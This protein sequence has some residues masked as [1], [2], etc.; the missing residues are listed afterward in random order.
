MDQ[1]QLLA[2]SCQKSS[3]RKDK[4]A[5]QGGGIPILREVGGERREPTEDTKH[6]SMSITEC[7]GWKG[8]SQ[9]PFQPSDGPAGGPQVEVEAPR[10]RAAPGHSQA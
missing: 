3:R 6:E 8:T 9:T 10:L 1:S 2:D 5:A 4:K 7:F